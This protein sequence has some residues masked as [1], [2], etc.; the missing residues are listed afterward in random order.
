[1]INNHIKNIQKKINHIENEINLN[2]TK[3]EEL[4]QVTD[5][6]LKTAC[7]DDEISKKVETIIPKKLIR[8]LN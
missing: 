1:M 3:I 7:T 6:I 4:Y 8:T 5:I 2:Q